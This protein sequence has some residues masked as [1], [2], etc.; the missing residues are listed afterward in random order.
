MADK[1]DPVEEASEESF[2]ASDAPAW[3]MGEEGALKVLN[4]PAD[5]RFELT[6]HG[7]TAFL[8]YGLDPP[9]IRLRHT[10]VPQKLR[11]G[12][13]GNAL[14]RAA[15]DHA[16][17]EGLKVIVRCP[18]VRAYVKRHPETGGLDIITA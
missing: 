4:N 17:R 15:L 5:H 3:T 6:I 9:S 12:G 16:R 14:V 8:D 1:I 2:P 7:E 11:G 13:V 10:E 18:F